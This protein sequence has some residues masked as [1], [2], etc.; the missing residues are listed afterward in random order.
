MKA[1]TA[2]DLLTGEAVFWSKGR[3]VERFADAELFD[4]EA[5]D[6]ALSAAEA[7][8]TVAVAP[9]LIDLQDTDLGPVPV[10]YRERV[11]ALGP[12]NHP[13]HGKQG[14]GRTRHRGARPRPR[15]GPLHGPGCP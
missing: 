11:R 5:A 2:N 3:W 10:S 8:P 12:T 6:A 15:R 14:R 4:G 13:Q 9:Y 7:Q 1:L